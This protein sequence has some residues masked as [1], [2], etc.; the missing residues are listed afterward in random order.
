[1]VSLC[2]TIHVVEGQGENMRKALLLFML[3][4]TLPAFAREYP[5]GKDF[6]KYE[7]TKTVSGKCVEYVTCVYARAGRCREYEKCTLNRRNDDYSCTSTYAKNRYYPKYY[8]VINTPNETKN[9][10]K[11]AAA[12]S[13]TYSV[14]ETNS[15]YYTPTNAGGVSSF[16]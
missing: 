5:G 4:L 13:F 9:P 12:V 16:K 2:F 10:P 14:K 6:S 3:L 8:Y 1:M 7:C 11:A 15:H